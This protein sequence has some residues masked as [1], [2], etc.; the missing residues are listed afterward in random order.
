MNINTLLENEF[1]KR[2]L[3]FIVGPDP[4][5]YTIKIGEECSLI[6]IDN[7][8]R[9][10]ASDGDIGRIPRFIDAIMGSSS[11]TKDSLSADQLYWCLEP[12]DYEKRADYYV[13]MSDRTD[14]ILVHLSLDHRLITWVTPSM[15]NS[16][17]LSELDAGQRAFSNLGRILSEA[18][19]EFQDIDG[20]NLGYISTSIPF[21]S[22]LILAPNLRTIM[23]GVLGWP[24]LAVVPNRDFLYLWAAQH[25]DFAQRVGGVVVR[26]YSQASYPISTE[27]YEISDDGIQAIGEFST[28]SK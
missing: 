5:R 16:L 7:L 15:L 11:M 18:T 4:N 26:E 19:V 17:G 9:D 3:E 12:N 6:S 28:P 1:Q 20:V 10:V 22:S 2:G 27:V 8:Q 13:S 21:K 23:E 25:T 14:R 24:L